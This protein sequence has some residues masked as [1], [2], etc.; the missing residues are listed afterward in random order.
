MDYEKTSKM[1]KALADPNRLKIVDILSDGSQC[2]CHLLDFFDFTQPALSH[3]MKILASAGIVS[4]NK[5]GTWNH[6]T[7]SQEFVDDFKETC[8]SLFNKN[9]SE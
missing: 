5:E 7:L 2:A 4:V 3:H 9:R 1:L 6:Y 8:Q